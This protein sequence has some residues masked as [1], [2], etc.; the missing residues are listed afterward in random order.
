M[1]DRYPNKP[2]VKSRVITEQE[3]EA[4]VPASCDG[5]G[6]RETLLAIQTRGALTC[7]PERKMLHDP[8][9][10]GLMSNGR[11]PAVVAVVFPSK[12]VRC[13]LHSCSEDEECAFPH[14]C[15]VDR[16]DLKASL[17]RGR[18]FDEGIKAVGRA[19]EDMTAQPCGKAAFD[20]DPNLLGRPLDPVRENHRQA[21]SEM[22]HDPF[23]GGYKNVEPPEPEVAW[24]REGE[25][26][27]YKAP[28]R[29]AWWRRLP[30]IRHIAAVWLS[31]QVH[32]YA[33]AW[34]EVGIGVGGPNEYDL[35]VVEGAWHGYW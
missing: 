17:E 4:G 1:M 12:F 30:L 26:A 34:A 27:G 35:W 23:V 29:R 32:S 28:D 7:C 20:G 19:L 9:R 13:G 24:K 10:A 15:V 33:G 14:D 5:C 16:R 21:L 31:W 8:S 18:G 2:L 3:L 11:S 6:S 22:G 25:A